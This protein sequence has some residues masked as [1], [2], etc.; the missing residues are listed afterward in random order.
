M[1]KVKEMDKVAEAEK[2]L[3][4]KRQEDVKNFQAEYQILCEKY[5]C[6]MSPVTE[7]TE[8]GTKVGLIP[9]VF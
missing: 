4:E 2:V 1:E 9:I 8:Q 3:Q 7:I 6:R 5:K